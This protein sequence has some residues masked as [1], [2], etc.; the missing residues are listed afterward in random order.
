M[1]TSGRFGVVLYEMLTGQ[2]PFEGET[3]SDTLAAVLRQEIDWTRLPADTPD[4]LRRL[5]RRCLERE[6]DEPAARCG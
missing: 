1:P 6:P 4:D 3:I 5:L 2:R